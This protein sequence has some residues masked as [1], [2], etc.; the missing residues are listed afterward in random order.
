MHLSP[1]GE[2]TATI[3]ITKAMLSQL[4]QRQERYNISWMPEDM[5]ASWLAPNRLLLYIYVA[6]PSPGLAKPAV[7]IDGKT[8]DVSL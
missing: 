2:Y 5:D 3:T 8:V 6:R 7:A 4:A 1:N